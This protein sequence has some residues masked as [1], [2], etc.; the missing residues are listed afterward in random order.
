MH[1][2]CVVLVSSQQAA[3]TAL[4]EGL[5]RR[6]A[7]VS[8]FFDAPGAMV[9]LHRS[10]ALVVV[11]P[12][13]APRGKVLVGAVKM[14]LPHVVCWEY[15]PEPG[16]RGQLA[17]WGQGSG[18]QEVRPEPPRRTPPN[19]SR[20]VAAAPNPAPATPESQREEREPIEPMVIT[21]EELAMLVR[22]LEESER[23]D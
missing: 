14:H 12:A 22:P 10:Q 18:E 20:P 23:S 2:N 15:R 19:R 8:V 13:T 5:R 3:P 4:L 6:G 21:P 9:A 1:A 16:G 7:K 11:D 17:P